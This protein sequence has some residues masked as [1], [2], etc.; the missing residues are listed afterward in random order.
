MSWPVILIVL[1]AALA[2]AAAW[3]ALVPAGLGRLGSEPHPARDYAEAVQRIEALRAAEG[4]AFHPQGRTIFLTHGQKTARVVIFAHGYTSA[5]EQ[6]RP[7]GQ[8]LFDLGYNV[9][10]AP[11]PHHGL[12]DRMTDEQARLTA[13]ELA[14]YGDEVV[15]IGRGLGEHITLAGLSGGGV[16]TAWAAQTR[17]D[18]DQA[19]I[20][21]AALGFQAIRRPL[22]V[23]MMNATLA[24]PNRFGWWDPAEQ[25][26]SGPDY[27]YPRYSRRALGQILRLGYGALG[28]ARAGA[29]AAKSIVVVTNAHD[30]SVDNFAAARLAEV[31]RTGGAKNLR[32][33]EFPMEFKLPH[34]LIDPNA[35]D[36]QPEVVFPKLVE[37]IEG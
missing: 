7:L 8:G 36:A 12:A 1:V 20:I 30:P 26:K 13:E 15:D 9:L 24:L 37:L 29:P 5:P 32:A 6:F 23:A 31:W 25:E 27:T 2:V 18:L 28:R 16:T 14:R 19:V 33:Y 17:A 21:S 11:L 34:D 10:I 4:A 35:T 3:V 22:T